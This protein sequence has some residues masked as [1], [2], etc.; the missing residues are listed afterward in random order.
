MRKSPHKKQTVVRFDDNQMEEIERRDRFR[1]LN[2]EKKASGSKNSIGSSLG[3][4]E[5]QNKAEEFEESGIIIK[6]LVR[7]NTAADIDYS[8]ANSPSR[9]K[10][11]DDSATNMGSLVS[12]QQN[13]SQKG[14][15]FSMAVSAI[16][17]ED[18][19]VSSPLSKKKTHLAL[20]GKELPLGVSP[21][22]GNRLAMKIA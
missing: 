1:R 10:R 13:A 8:I 22:R 17:L 6:N 20:R 5:S 18:S 11:A 9:R 4:D 21:V 19:Q 16:E 14:F 2:T 15:N 12:E 3:D 7:I